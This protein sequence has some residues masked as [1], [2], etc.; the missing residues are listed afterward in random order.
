MS[1]RRTSLAILAGIAMIPFAFSKIRETLASYLASVPLLKT[2][3]TPIP[4]Q[5]VVFENSAGQQRVF[6]DFQGKHL[7]V[8]VWATWCPPCRKEMPALDRL[9]AKLG[10]K[11]EPEIVAI[12]VD[13]VSLDQLRAFYSIVGISN[14]AIYKGDQAEIFETLGILG[15]PT[16]LLID[17]DGKEIARLIGPTVW[18]ASEITDQL[19]SLVAISTSAN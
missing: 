12:S 19:S 3:A 17:H 14:L 7:L 4:I 16:T 9:Q 5:P 1:S 2:H 8:N 6:S 18:D 15:L 10:L 13:P 11:A